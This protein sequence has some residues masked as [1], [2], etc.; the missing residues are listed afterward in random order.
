[1]A[2]EL[3]QKYADIFEEQ[4]LETKLRYY[5]A[6][7]EVAVKQVVAIECQEKC[8]VDFK[9]I[10]PYKLA[11]RTEL[12]PKYLKNRCKIMSK[13]YLPHRLMRNIVGRAHLLLPNWICD[14]RRYREQGY[15]DFNKSSFLPVLS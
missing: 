10:P 9:W 5:H 11:G 2:A 14:F 6:I 12:Y 4:M 1:M 15:L 8:N 13:Y 3:R 7:H